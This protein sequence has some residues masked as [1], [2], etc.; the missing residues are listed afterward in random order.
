M[1]L[2][3]LKW[4][5]WLMFWNCC[6]HKKCTLTH[7]HTHALWINSCLRYQSISRSLDLLMWI[8][9][10]IGLTATQYFIYFSDV[11]LMSKCQNEVLPAGIWQIPHYTHTHKHTLWPP[12]T[13][14][15]FARQCKSVRKEIF[16]TCHMTLFSASQW[17][18][19]FLCTKTICFFRKTT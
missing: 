14:V 3:E 19:I 7:K 1:Y 12:V 9:W 10:P 11:I 4:I 16:V 15:S 2:A 6:T 5:S 17:L 8:N 18:C 13:Q